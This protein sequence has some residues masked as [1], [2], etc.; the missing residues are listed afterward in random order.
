MRLMKY[1]SLVSSMLFGPRVFPSSIKTTKWIE[2]KCQLLEYLKNVNPTFKE[3]VLIWFENEKQN[4]SIR[5]WKLNFMEMMEHFLVGRKR[6]NGIFNEDWNTKSSH[7]GCRKAAI[8]SHSET[9]F[10]FF[11]SHKI[12]LK[13]EKGCENH[14][15][16]F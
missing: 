15:H 1:S 13:V 7:F 5:K 2:G 3:K 11:L 12:H 6:F 9:I 14:L 8:I 10:S 4:N 16:P